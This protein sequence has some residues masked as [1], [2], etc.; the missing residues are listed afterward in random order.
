MIYNKKTLLKYKRFISETFW[1][2]KLL[3]KV[4]KSKKKSHLLIKFGD[5]ENVIE[6]LQK[7]QNFT[8]KKKKILI[9]RL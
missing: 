1:K 3:K 8:P 9:D 7:F 6:T 5:Y 2:P 4:S